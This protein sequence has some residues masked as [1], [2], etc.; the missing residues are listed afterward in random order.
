VPPDNSGGDVNAPGPGN[1]FK[2]YVK[3][4]VPGDYHIEVRWSYF[5]GG[6]ND[7]KTNH[8]FFRNEQV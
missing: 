6:S 5:D 4:S 3:T 2:T 1:V 7:W 8:V